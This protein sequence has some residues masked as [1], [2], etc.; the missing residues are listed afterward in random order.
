MLLYRWV[1]VCRLAR[2]QLLPAM[3]V[4]AV[5]TACSGEAPPASE[6]AARPVRIYQVVPVAREM[7]R[8][9][10]GRVAEGNLVDLG[11]EIEGTL[12]SLPFGGPVG[13]SK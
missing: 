4:L 1:Q 6:A 2:L 11:F 9:F 3:A 7:E 12:L 5:L 13:S 10:I 8:R